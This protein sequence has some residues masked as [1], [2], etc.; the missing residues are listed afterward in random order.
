MLR[1][2]NSPRDLSLSPEMRSLHASLSSAD[3]QDLNWDRLKASSCKVDGRSCGHG[4]LNATRAMISSR[5]Q[6]GFV[7]SRHARVKAT[8]LSKRPTYPRPK[9]SSDKRRLL[10]NGLPCWSWT[11]CTGSSRGT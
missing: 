9:R 11:R 5:L 1:F 8:T 4:V 2:T 7:K 6:Q 10:R 3:S